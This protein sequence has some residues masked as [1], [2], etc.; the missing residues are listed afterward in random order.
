MVDR[1]AVQALLHAGQT[2]RQI[3]HQRGIARRTLQR[4]ALEPPVRTADGTA[5]GAACGLGH[6]GIGEATTTLLRSW[7][8]AEPTLPPREKQRRLPA[9]GTPLGLSMIYRVLGPGRAAIPADVMVRC[10]GVAGEFA[11]FD[12]GVADVLL[13]TDTPTEL[14]RALFDCGCGIE[15]CT[16]RAPAQQGSVEHLV[17]LVKPAPGACGSCA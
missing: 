2:P 17:G 12:F 10:E 11:Q 9:L 7:V 13:T 1:H 15:L 6:S 5:A 14:V 4:M 3:A 16:P 8:E